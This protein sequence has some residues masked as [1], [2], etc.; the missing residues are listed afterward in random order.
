MEKFTL[1]DFENEINENL[2]NFTPI[3]INQEGGANSEPEFSDSDDEGNN[4][5]EF[6]NSEDE[7]NDMPEFSDD[8]YNN[9]TEKP[10]L[11]NSQVNKD[12]EDD[13]DE[14]DA[15]EDESEKPP[16][17]E[18]VGPEVNNNSNLS[19]DENED[20][21]P[22]RDEEPQE[23]SESEDYIL[24]NEEFEI[25]ETEQEIV[26]VEK[27]S[28]P[29]DKIIAN[30]M[31]Q[32]LDLFN[33]LVRLLPEKKR[34]NKFLLD[35]I[36]N[37]LNNCF[38]LKSNFSKF[39]E[40]N[41]IVEAKFKTELYKPLLEEY[42][43]NNYNTNYLT[44]IVNSKKDIY[45]VQ[46]DDEEEMATSNLEILLEDT[47]KEN[48]NIINNEEKIS[49]QVTIRLKYRKS[50]AR[51]NYSYKNEL[52][53]TYNTM[54]PYTP[55]EGYNILLNQDTQTIR[56]CFRKE[57]TAFTANSG[58]KNVLSDI[59]KHLGPTVFNDKSMVV[60][61]KISIT[62]FLKNGERK[63]NHT[64]LE[65][66]NNGEEILSK[67]EI[68]DENISNINFDMKIGDNVELCFY[69]D[70]RE[71]KVTGVL[72][73]IEND[74]YIIKPNEDINED[75][76]NVLKIPKKDDGVVIS[77]AID[78]CEKESTQ[79][80]L[81]PKNDISLD[82]YKQLLNSIIPSNKKIIYS[83]LS[84][85][86]E[87]ESLD[88]LENILSIYKLSISDL[89]H[90]LFKPIAKTLN[91]NIGKLIKI[92]NS[93]HRVFESL[94]GK[95]DNYKK[96]EIK[97]IN[98]KL[99]E[100]L[101]EFYGPYPYYG[102]SIDSTVERYRWLKN[103]FDNGNLFYKN[104][105]V[106]ILKQLSTSKEKIQSAINNELQDL[107]KKKF[108]LEGMIEQKRQ[109]YLRS[110]APKCPDYRLVKV[111]HSLEDL[112]NDNNKQIPVDKDKVIYGSKTNIVQP[113]DFCLLK[114]SDTHRKIYRRISL[115]S[116]ELWVL[117][118]GKNIDKILESNKEFCIQQAQNLD[119][120]EAAFFKG[121][122]CN[123]DEDSN[124]CEINELI[125]LN[126]SIKNVELKIEEKTTNLRV[127]QISDVH[128]NTI[129]QD[130]NI[131]KQNLKL[132][133]E[134]E[135][136][137][138]EYNVEK[139]EKIKLSVDE[140]NSELYNKIDLYMEKI[141]LLPTEQKYS[142][143]N[144][145]YKKYGRESENDTENPLNIYCKVGNK[146]LFC[147][148]HL[149]IMKYY[150]EKNI[151][152]EILSEILE[153][154]SIEDSGM[155]W[156]KNCGQELYIS[157]FEEIEGFGRDGA[158]IVVTE[159]LQEEE[160][161][162][163]GDTNSS[164]ILETLKNYLNQEETQ[165]LSED[166]LDIIRIIRAITKI[167]GI[168]LSLDDEMTVYKN[169]NNIVSTVTKS[170]EEWIQSQKKLPKN[171]A[172]IDDIYNSYKIRNNI[173]YCCA[174]L[175][176]I[177]QI[178][179]PEYVPTKP[180]PKCVMGLQGYPLDSD[181]NNTS[182]LEYLSCIL[183]NLR[184]S[185]SS[186]KCLKKIKVKDALLK[187]INQM[188]KDDFINDRLLKK[189]V[190]L[191]EKNDKFKE[192]PKMDWKEFKPPL[193]RIKININLDEPN[194]SLDL[195]LKK[196]EIVDNI[197]N[198]SSI[199]NTLFTPTPLG[200]SCCLDKVDMENYYDYFDK[201]SSNK[202]RKINE[203]IMKNPVS[204]NN[205]ADTTIF[206]KSLFLNSDFDIETFNKEIF[207]DEIS[208]AEIR[209][210][211]LK[212]IVG[213]YNVG[214]EHIYDENGIC[215]L[216]GD[217]RNH[218]MNREYKLEDYEVLVN[219]L[220][221]SKLFS[222]NFDNTI[223]DS[224]LNTI[225]LV[226]ESNDI[227]KTDIYLNKLVSNLEQYINSKDLKKIDSL[228]QDLEEQVKVENDEL[229]SLITTS[230][231]I[232]DR[233][234]LNPVIYLINSLGELQDIFVE[235]MKTMDAPKAEK[236]LFTKKTKL[237]KQ[238][239]QTYLLNGLNT[240]K[241]NKFYEKNMIS[242]P[243]SWKLD[244][245]YI[246][247]LENMVVSNTKFIKEMVE[248]DKTYI[249]NML[250]MVKGCIRK[251]N[252]LIGKD[253][254][255]D[256]QGKI[257]YYSDMTHRNCS[258]LVHYIFLFTFKRLL[259]DSTNIEPLSLSKKIY[260]ND[261]EVEVI[262][263]PEEAVKKDIGVSDI[264]DIGSLEDIDDDEPIKKESSKKLL[265]EY[266]LETAYE[267]RML[268][269]NDVLYN[270]IKNIMK[271]QQFE[272]KHT[273]S[274][275]EEVIEKK[276]DI[277][278]E[279][280]LKFIEDLSKE[281]RQSFKAMIALGLDTW[282]QLHSKD[283]SM[284]FDAPIISEESEYSAEEMDLINRQKAQ[285]ELGNMN[286]EQYQSWLASQ[287]KTQSEDRLAYDEREVLED[288]DE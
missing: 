29:E 151:S 205:R 49:E 105:V 41:D 78:N 219:A 11:D 59:N 215:I 80:Y 126:Q 68:S 168:E 181:I 249:N 159:E 183:E 275:I 281:S 106:N 216:T 247:G 87:L 217:I 8:E 177:L 208:G 227:L 86:N 282:K 236:I 6:S 95:L 34:D 23:E 263:E 210:L 220:N 136:K 48:S 252:L 110:N 96:K 121:A 24:D 53:E 195:A 166:K 7:G 229:I 114:I 94:K 85:I 184:K 26:I 40:N 145:L 271:K 3:S 254:H 173:L 265:D 269:I 57:C 43:N 235:N 202:I 143:M 240:I 203:L 222:K 139:Y 58:Y 112:E 189:R 61:E 18:R 285:E 191:S 214:K 104:I 109:D 133:N 111:Y 55:K 147:K 119:D 14:D 115:D 76:Y 65:K 79:V 192:I 270:I 158:R 45:T 175:F 54:N 170:K 69:E 268:L 73:D 82:E 142:M 256:N 255:Y 39:N 231:K 204:K 124:T 198:N 10:P 253:H 242:I 223:N 154:Y 245:S 244:P 163:S 21:E 93:K 188:I 176:I 167:M 122:T 19:D 187:L 144:V 272:N 63:N 278:K 218:I 107:Y 90:E 141:N 194:D 179:I 22:I 211:Y 46:N 117:E 17:E 75:K 165:D 31:D 89:T 62:G 180:H 67:S 100:S 98:R 209:E 284:Y 38:E 125:K 1:E 288:D 273:Q 118:R 277:Q 20:D 33:E 233:Q 15:D 171:K 248:Q 56:D 150:V 237:I 225:K 146:V 123:F 131:L 103:S 148:H 239:L 102:L 212:F 138:Y 149:E 35:N 207:P 77:K 274:H 224:S 161:M 25:A 221:K 88:E 182:G 4:M 27:E 238:Y 113:G 130:L 128:K 91:S 134:L 44:P 226:L 9:D 162:P 50:Q 81:F 120:L 155:Y 97:I 152:Q 74:D 280:N 197:I 64:L 228:W 71:I 199:E 250:N 127:I 213:G 129:E 230:L 196:I 135:R 287:N 137:I 276:M 241:N 42:L 264:N 262:I 164:V 52:N 185:N 51:L 243:K 279:E 266:D 260:E 257:K 193:D 157:E 30:D 200:N 186:W 201:K 259:D 32:R 37:V 99:L 101:K 36:N 28:I 172:S 169:T 267:N 66:I 174:Q 251:I 160:D 83:N 232:K 246:E 84:K 13:E 47:T 258:Y 206:I 70:K 153:K 60:G 156:C 12:K 116:G 140:E 16:E 132:Y 190:Y 234:K 108:D 286:E 283:K 178:A 92:A 261:D 5:P 2:Y 72:I